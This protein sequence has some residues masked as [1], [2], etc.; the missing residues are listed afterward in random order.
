MLEQE[1]FRLTSAFG[2]AVALKSVRAE[3]RLEGLLLRMKL[4]QSY[5]N[6]GA[7]TIETIYTFPLAWGATLLG[8][9]VEIGGRRLQG[10]VIERQ[11][12]AERYENA[13]DEGD[14]PVMVEKDPHGLYT[15]N[16]GNLKP[17]EE[18]AIELEYAQLLRFEQG[19]IRVTVP[20]TIAPRYGDE[21]AQGGLGAHASAA[22]SDGV[23]YPF[24]LSLDIVGP[25]A[26]AK[27]ESPS[28]A[29]AV[30]AGDNVLRITL[31]RNGWLDRDFV[32]SLDGLEGRA[33]SAASRGADGSHAVLASF[34]PRLPAAASAPLALKILVDCSGS[35][36][37]SSI[38]SARR[39]LREVMRALAPEDR[40]SYSRFGSRVQHLMRRVEPCA[41]AVAGRIAAA[42]DGTDADMGGTELPAAL[43]S[44]ID[45]VALPGHGEGADILLITDGEVWAIDDVLRA[46]R[47]RGHRVFAVGVGNAPA[48]SLLRRLAE[49]TGGACE[50]VSPSEDLAAAVV[51][52]FHRMR[53]ARCASL[54]VD[55]GA[56]PRWQSALPASLFDGETV[57]VF[58]RFDEPPP[59]APALEWTTAGAPGE[60]QAGRD[61]AEPA[62]AR[63]KAAV[64]EAGPGAAPAAADD[65]VSRLAAARQ[66]EESED[67]AERLALSIAHQL[68]SDRSALFL[69]HLREGEDKAPGSPVLHRI[70]QMQAADWHGL[71]PRFGKPAPAWLDSAFV[72]YSMSS[73][74][75]SCDAAPLADP[76]DVP[77]FLRKQPPAGTSE[78]A[79]AVRESADANACGP[80]ELLRRFDRAARGRASFGD[81]LPALDKR[82][83]PAEL[84]RLVR[85]WALDAAGRDAAW[86]LLL[87]HLNAL[88][89]PGA[90]LSAEALE[91]LRQALAGLDPSAVQPMRARLRAWLPSADADAW[92][93][94]MLR[95]ALADA[96]G[97]PA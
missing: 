80:A 34:C 2:D 13:I 16:L 45:D 30:T 40:V 81:A 50:L 60:T 85:A 37:G 6:E 57:H 54:Q 94:R 84:R 47:A 1:S 14:T 17:G 11:E 31:E 87:E 38:A 27:L 59:A 48:E 58:A 5:R 19:R 29:I 8:L 78:T 63:G 22:S 73:V 32:V 9:A 79:G 36:A 46:G 66:I 24:T 23:A 74:S 10:T 7:G 25:L 35:M 12:A 42:I 82:G 97:S 91:L 65:T 83:L 43:L 93:A 75:A 4:R 89:A 90:S 52:T 76:F 51:R 21:H 49:E 39:A 61:T 20:T 15:A 33:Y 28:H 71:G 55:W 72:S 88:L 96:L 77:A 3:G 62:A 44:T 26:R 69:V 67:P 95:A 86:A 53:G 68:L 56:A 64:P 70:A 41:P 92:D 18:A